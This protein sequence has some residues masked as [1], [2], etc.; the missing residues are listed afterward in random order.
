M[1]D[2]QHPPEEDERA[3]EEVDDD[4]VHPQDL[5]RDHADR[6]PAGQVR[7]GDP[8]QGGGA[9]VGD[10][11][12]APGADAVDPPPEDEVIEERRQHLLEEEDEG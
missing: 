6:E 4:V 7:G 1:A 2:A 5:P 12:V 9:I 10:G 8:G 3:G 11:Q